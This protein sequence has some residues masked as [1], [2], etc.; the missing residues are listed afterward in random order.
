MKMKVFVLATIFV[1][2]MAS[3]SGTSTPIPEATSLPNLLS[4]TPVATIEPFTSEQ[5]EQAFADINL[6]PP[7]IPFAPNFPERVINGDWAINNLQVVENEKLVVNGQVRIF[8]AGTLVLKN[9]ELEI[10][11]P[12]EAFD[13]GNRE[14]SLF[15]EGGGSIEFVDCFVSTQ[16]LAMLGGHD[17][18]ITIRNCTFRNVELSFHRASP[19]VIEGNTFVLKPDQGISAAIELLD[20]HG[21][22]ISSNTIIGEPGSNKYWRPA[23][24]GINLYY[25]EQNEIRNNTII[26]TRSGISLYA[27]SQNQ[28][29]GNMWTGPDNRQGDGGLW[30]SH[31]SNSNI[32]ENNILQNSGSTMLSIN[33]SVNNKISGNTLLNSGHGLVL[34]YASGNIITDNI[35]EYTL[36]DGVQIYRSYDNLIA[37]NQINHAGVGIALFTSWDNQVGGNMIQGTDR[38]FYVFDARQNLVWGNE[39]RD[40]IQ[41][42]LV[43]ESVENEFTENNFIQSEL[44]AMEDNSTG[45][46]NTW[47]RNFWEDA[48]NLIGEINPASQASTVINITIPE[49]QPI[50]FGEIKEDFILVESQIIWE[51]QTTTINGGISIESGG[52][53]VI[54]NSTIN[55][56]PQG[57]QV[58]IWI[59]VMPGGKLEIEG[60]KIFGPEKDHPL[61]I[62][63]HENAEI[64]MK[65]SE[66][67]NAGYW[68]GDFGCAIGYSGKLALIENNLFDNVYCAFSSEPPATNIQFLSNTVVNTIEAVAIIGDAPNTTIASNHIS[69][70]ANWGI[71]L[72]SISPNIGSTVRGNQV[73]NSW[74]MGIFDAYAGSF[75]IESNNEFFN[76]KGP[77]LVLLKDNTGLDGRQFRPISL[78]ATNVQLDE[79][80]KV[81]FNLMPLDVDPFDSPYVYILSLTVNGLEIDHQEVVINYG[82]SLLVTLEGVAPSAGVL[83]LT[84]TC[85]C[86]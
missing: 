36:T 69:Q 43:V 27:S 80:V 85:Q 21:T 10:N 7:P 9:A 65:D 42:V 29:V 72:W 34:S 59:H 40:S 8:G 68:V 30:L 33:Q 22:R 2:L 5:P 46:K 82:E 57:M 58:E 25:S 18:K 45:L 31:W 24:L 12:N 3:C 74:G 48:P 81:A 17:P 53:L 63:V 23:G 78:T 15:I 19:A 1:L 6:I 26:G 56:E 70:S 50:D 83:I 4:N 38:G 49:F 75:N 51:E 35:I 41:S 44:P 47:Q 55:F 84:A 37:Y 76:L 77:G 79:N 67:H 52:T 71:A 54:R 86:D 32:I 20:S 14:T 64:V 61:L 13:V 11:Y 73:E 39:V 66:L 16:T 60:S 62:K 28:I